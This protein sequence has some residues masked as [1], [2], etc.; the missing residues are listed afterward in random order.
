[1]EFVFV[2][3]PRGE[4]D[5]AVVAPQAYGTGTGGDVGHCIAEPK[6]ERYVRSLGHTEAI[7]FEVRVVDEAMIGSARKVAEHYSRH[8]VLLKP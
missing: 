4:A 6:F 7:T 5:H 2:P 8:V 1:M 3:S